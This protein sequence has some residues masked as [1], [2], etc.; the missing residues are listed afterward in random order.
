MKNKI[1]TKSGRLLSVLALL[2]IFGVSCSSSDESQLQQQKPIPVV[3]QQA[4]YGQG[5]TM[6]RYSG[7][8]RSDR[9]I[10]MSTK[11][12]GRITELDVEEGDFVKK[13]KVLVRIKDDN[14]KAQKNQVQAQLIQAR[15][16]L[17]NTETNYNR[18]KALHE[19]N[20]ATQKELDDIST[21]YEMAKAKVQTLES[22]LQ[23]VED[24][25]EYTTLTAP[26]D[27][28]VVSKRFSEGDMAAPGQPI[29]TFE[30]D[31]MLKVNITVPESD[32]ALFTLNDTVSVDVKAV[33]YQNTKGIV[34]NI[35]QSGNRG[36]R[37]FAVEVALPKLDK[38][39]GVKSGMFAEVTI[40]SARN[41]TITVPQ[42]AIIERGQLTGLYTLNNESEVVLRWVRLG[43]YTG[44]QVEVLSGLGPGEQYIAQVDRPFTEGQKVTVQ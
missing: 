8:V 29:I 10:N 5:A 15:A 42:S 21:K 35:N 19:Q 31:N 11:V 12:M 3:T 17:K 40:R 4:D 9:S 6:N 36:S 25:L 23:E 1:M 38:S 44:S 27:G 39:S 16:G 18:I 30:Q 41:R 22:K 43:D 7:N 26:F 28:Y 34:T 24:M 13:G 33:G 20:S 2:T 32:I 37:Q 14:L